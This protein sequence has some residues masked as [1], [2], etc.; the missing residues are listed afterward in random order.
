MNNIT[1]LKL[2]YFFKSLFFFSP[3]ITLFYF[4][5]GLD[6]FQIVSLEAVLIIAVLFSEVPTGIIADKIG[7][8]LSLSILIF[9]YII[10]ILT[11]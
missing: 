1:K 7:R 3:I 10:D 9:L 4:S 2:I 8:K 5:R 6:T 11:Q